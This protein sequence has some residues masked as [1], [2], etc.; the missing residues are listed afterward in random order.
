MSAI[1][2]AQ[3]KLAPTTL[4]DAEYDHKWEL[5][6]QYTLLRKSQDPR[7]GEI[8][9][10][11]KKNTNEL[12]FAKEKLTSNKQSAANDIRELKSRVA[13]NR[14]NLQKMLGYS[15]AVK[16]ELCSTNYLTQGFYEFPKSDLAKEI[17]TRGQS[18]QGFPEAELS[19]I[20]SQSLNGLSSLHQERLTH[21]DIRPQYLGY[22]REAHEAQILDRLADPTPL[23]KTQASHIIA[24]KPLYLCPE[25]YKKLQG[26][27][28]LIKYDPAKNDL[29][30]LG[31]SVLEAGNGQ[32]IQ[33]I[34]NSNGTINQA[35][36]DKHLGNF[37]SQYHGAYLNNFVQANLAANESARPTSGELISRLGTWN[38][39]MLIQGYNSQQIV[40][41][42]QQ[43]EHSLFSNTAPDNSWNKEVKV[44]S[45]NTTALSFMKA[46]L[47]TESHFVENVQEN[48]VYASNYP[49][50]V[51][52]TN[53]QLVPNQYTVVQPQSASKSVVYQNYQSHQ[54][55]DYA[56]LSDYANTYSTPTQSYVTSAP[57][58]IVYT[59]SPQVVYTQPS[60][61]VYT[62]SLSTYEQGRS[63]SFANAPLSNQ[64]VYA[65]SSN[66]SYLPTQGTSYINT[67]PT[68]TYITSETPRKVSYSNLPVQTQ[69]YVT[70]QPNIVTYAQSPSVRWNETPVTSFPSNISHSER[71]VT[72]NPFRNDNAL[73]GYY[74]PSVVYTNETNP[75]QTASFSRVEDRKSISFIN[76]SETPRSY[77]NTIET[78]DFPTNYQTISS[79]IPSSGIKNVISYEEF[80]RLK[81][82]NPSVKL[83]EAIYTDNATHSQQYISNPVSNTTYAYGTPQT[84]NTTTIEQIKQSAKNESLQLTPTLSANKTTTRT[85]YATPAEEGDHRQW[86]DSNHYQGEQT[87]ETQ[88]VEHSQ[89]QQGHLLQSNYDNQQV[90]VQEGN[91]DDHHDDQEVVRNVSYGYQGNQ[92]LLSNLDNKVR[93]YRIENG[94]K[95]EITNS[96]QVYQQNY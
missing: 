47:T 31:L 96:P 67:A 93:R 4:P 57:Q 40:Q 63:I 56:N 91:N 54:P 82:Q 59:Q 78:R 27:D 28:K 7:F 37:K 50:T 17:S 36:L 83:K 30:A 71:V 66:V 85:V 44:E 80:Q 34:Y 45:Q 52:Q 61:T 8:L 19:S 86:N 51:S 16:K 2:T 43:Q 5:E 12:I 18:N 22:N 64:S 41:S 69:S 15:T 39:A 92:G 38:D 13:L 48:K 24:K 68:Q 84:Y 3:A 11:K 62:P 95:V 1:N 20:A 55:T 77:T 29:Y 73:S 89:E 88:Y 6:P 65:P 32:S 87:H 90:Y 35:N 46:P 14:P 10:Y 76:H 81:Q 58:Q 79:V 23:E 74:Q 72:T 21:G 70:S 26:K 42:T 53:V 75:I 9:I 94:Q 49:Q 33:D 60:Q 25:L